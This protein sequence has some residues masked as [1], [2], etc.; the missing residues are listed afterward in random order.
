MYYVQAEREKRRLEQLERKQL[1]KQLLE[2]E[3][4]EIGGKSGP[5]KVTQAEI[6]AA[7]RREREMQSA[8]RASA[9]PKGVSEATPME[10]NPNQLLR[11]RQLEGE[12]DARTIDEAL[13]VLSEAKVPVDVHPEKRMKA[14]YV[15]FE[16]REM[17]RLKAENPNLRMSQ[18]K[19]MLKKDWMKSPENPMNQH[20]SGTS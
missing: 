19:Q 12:I 10:E 18:L 4:G 7:Q 16:E 17:P 8:A 13:T 2:E 11:Q 15:V 5:S 6:E 14:A 9:L 3:E 20:L 1:N